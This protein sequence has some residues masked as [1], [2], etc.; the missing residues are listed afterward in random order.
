M[1]RQHLLGEMLIRH[2]GDPRGRPGETFL[3][4]FRG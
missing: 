1:P 2:A 3:D 4:E